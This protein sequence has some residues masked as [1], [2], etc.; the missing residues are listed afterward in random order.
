MTRSKTLSLVA[1]IAMVSVLQAEGAE[2]KQQPAPA[3]EKHHA[4]TPQCRIVEWWFARH[5]EKIGQM[6]KGDIDL[7]MIGDSITH[8]FES[9]GAKVWK[10]YFEPRK[11]INLGFGGAGRAAEASRVRRG[12]LAEILG[13]RPAG[14]PPG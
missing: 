11:A 10:Q 8:N 14:L 3:V 9:V 6:S 2:P 5:A 4:V 12:L 7:L 13:Q 1:V